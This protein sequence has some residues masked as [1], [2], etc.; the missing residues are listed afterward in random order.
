[1]NARRTSWSPTG[2]AALLSCPKVTAQAGAAL[3]THTP[4]ITTRVLAPT[5]TSSTPQSAVSRSGSPAMLIGL[6][7]ALSVSA[8]ALPAMCGS[9]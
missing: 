5:S 6:V 3:D 1:M 7:S 2:Q 9:E 8:K 4:G